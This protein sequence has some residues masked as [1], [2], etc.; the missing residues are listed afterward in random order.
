MNSDQIKDMYISL[1]NQ[2]ETPLCVVKADPPRF[3]IVTVNESFK[4]N[5]VTDTTGIVGK[6]VFEVYRPYDEQ[7]AKQFELLRT[8]LFD[9]LISKRSIRLPI[10]SFDIVNA[11]NKV[12]IK[13]YWQ[14]EINPVLGLDEHVEYIMC[15]TRNVTE[16]ETNK[17]LIVQ[18][19]KKE[20][21]LLGEL[22]TV[23]KKLD[24]ANKELLRTN[25]K[26]T[27]AVADLSQ[28]RDQLHRL[29]NE[30]EQRVDKRTK[31]LAESEAKFKS[32][33]NFIPQIA[34]TSATDGEVTF[35]NDRWYEY[36]GLNYEQTKSWGWKEV[37][38]PDD[39][40]YNLS[41]YGNI[42]SNNVAGEFEIRE[43]R[44]DGIY[45]WHLVRMEPMIN[46]AGYVVLWIGTATDIQDIKNIQQSKDDFISVAS[47]EL[48]TPLTALSASIQLLDHL[49]NT[50]LNSS[51]PKLITQA[52]KS[53]LKVTLLISRLLNASQINSK[54]LMLN[55]SSFFLLECV[56]DNISDLFTV[57]QRNILING[58]DVEIV[59]DQF[60]VGQVIVNLVSN[61]I[62][63][64]PAVSDIIIELSEQAG[65][66]QLSV[67]DFGAGIDEEQQP[68]L[69]DR[70]FRADHK[71]FQ[72][73]GI[74]LG[75]FISAKVIKA[76]GGEIGVKSE[77]GK[78]S[79]FWFTLP[80]NSEASQ[81]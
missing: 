6:E 19:D 21:E 34:W 69:F 12:T 73:Q 46:E 30:L 9:C 51:V 11:G 68:L 75:L 31:Q 78:G 37:I 17:L 54:G 13:T 3:T 65:N 33:L 8:A 64:S 48:R 2:T 16:Q 14:F 56:N 42:L 38:H 24:L 20:Q 44:H 4:R 71:N 22:K 61:A 77:K 5:T 10:I 53:M 80:V 81:V 74:G 60:Q 79:T 7:S 25:T 66:I 36:T 23:N 45:K 67:R 49:K 39:L 52:N 59:A 28:S 57:Y 41:A 32:I 70:Y 43:K 63:Y 58:K 40:A 15:V 55:K 62:K 26:L 72:Y 50:P 18:A 29:N 35:Y 47:H 27:E 1:F 76:H